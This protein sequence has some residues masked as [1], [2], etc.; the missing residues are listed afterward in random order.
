MSSDNWFRR[1]TW[2][3]Y[4]EQAFFDRLRRSRSAWA[5]VKILP[6]SIGSIVRR[7]GNSLPYSLGDHQ[8]PDA[9]PSEIGI[10]DPPFIRFHLHLEDVR[11]S[12]VAARQLIGEPVSSVIRVC[13]NFLANNLEERTREA[14]G[15]SW[16][17]RGRA[18]E[19][20]GP[21]T[22]TIRRVKSLR[23]SRDHLERRERLRV[24]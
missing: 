1:T 20:L 16:C 13:G 12:T 5:E 15:L 17:G 3:A 6:L 21:Q 11:S 10:Y 23:P 14:N 19:L 7:S 9:V 2:T 8:V 18:R 24:L 4:D 22:P